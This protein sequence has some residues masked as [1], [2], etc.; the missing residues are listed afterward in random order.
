MDIKIYLNSGK[1]FEITNTDI[2]KDEF[3]Q[4]IRDN[5][6]NH[7]VRQNIAFMSSMVELIEFKY[8]KLG[9]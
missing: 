7:M 6:I 5:T 8:T 4:M 3:L 2:S 9:V 1:T